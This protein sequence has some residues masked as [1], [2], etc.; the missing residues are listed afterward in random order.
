MVNIQALYTAETSSR[1]HSHEGI[2][3]VTDQAPIAAYPDK[4][5]TGLR[6]GVRL[7]GRQSVR[8]VVENCGKTLAAPRRIDRNSPVLN[9][10][11]IQ[12]GLRC[13]NRA[14]CLHHY[15]MR[16]KHA[17]EAAS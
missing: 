8:I 17:Q 6:D 7:S 4:A 1:I 2:A 13:R 15:D 10:R 3:I 16:Q 11:G 5:F 9:A 14:N 12:H